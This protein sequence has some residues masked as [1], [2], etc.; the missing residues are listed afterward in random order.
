MFVVTWIR[1]HPFSGFLILLL[2]VFLFWPVPAD[3]LHYSRSLYSQNQTLLS[4]QVS[5]DGQWCLPLSDTLP[6]AFEKAIITYEDAYF[7]YH[8]GINPVSMVKA[9]YSY[10]RQRKIVRGA[11]TLRMQVMRMRYKNANRS[12]MNKLVES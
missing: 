5:K 3:R 6:E 10:L 12:L 1:K 7:Y 11:S 2:L 8:P 4:A 9:F